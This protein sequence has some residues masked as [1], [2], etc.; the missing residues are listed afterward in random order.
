[1]ESGHKFDAMLFN[2]SQDGDLDGVMQALAGGGRV[3]MRTSKGFTPLLV[4]AGYGHTDICGLLLAY[5]SNVNE[6]KPG[7]KHTALHLAAGKGHQATVE[8]LL[9]WGAAV[10]HQDHVGF[11]PL[12]GACEEGHLACVLTLLKA[13]ANFS[14]SS[15]DGN[16]PIHAAA[17]K[18]RVEIV[19]TLLEHGCSLNMVSC[20]CSE[21][22]LSKI[23]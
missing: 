9:T 10:D 17:Q 6:V 14:L 11:T 21:I 18:N 1:M 8:A 13:G 7:E 3:S 20:T 23:S 4:A 22:T 2:S 19:K 16:F 12:L 15:N 5:G